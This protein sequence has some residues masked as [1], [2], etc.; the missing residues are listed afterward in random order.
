MYDIP[1]QIRLLDKDDKYFCED[2]TDVRGVLATHRI[3]GE[4][5]SF[6]AE[7]YYLCEKHTEKVR[8]CKQDSLLE[9]PQTCPECGQVA[10]LIQYRDVDEGSCAPLREHCDTCHKQYYAPFED[11][12]F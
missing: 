10:V 1:G 7:Y 3:T 8:Q 5:D 6:G 4:V 12:E 9:E 11:D 2:C